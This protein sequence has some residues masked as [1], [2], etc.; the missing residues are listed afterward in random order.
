MPLLVIGFD[1]VQPPFFPDDFLSTI[2]SS[3]FIE[4][5][6]V[7]QKF[8]VVQRNAIQSCHFYLFCRERPLSNALVEAMSFGLLY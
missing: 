3:P 2:E 4:L 5:L 6:G 7:F 8:G 1:G